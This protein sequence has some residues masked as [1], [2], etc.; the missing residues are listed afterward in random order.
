MRLLVSAKSVSCNAI[1]GRHFRGCRATLAFMLVCL[2]VFSPAHADSG[3]FEILTADSRLEEGKWTVD[4]RI[5]LLLSKEAIAALESG[6]TLR[7]QFLYEVN[8]SRPF[9]PDETI[10][11]RKQ[12]IELRYLSLSQRYA[13]HNLSSGEQSSFATLLSALRSMGQPR[14]FAVIDAA[15]LQPDEDY[16]FAIRA[17]LARDSLPGPLQMLAFWRG[18]FILESEWYRWTLN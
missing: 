1:S 8:R 16:W 12:N 5:D 18:D 6:V 2:A 3:R 17:V 10:K 7:I 9:W 13:V 15:E 14:D 11:D 4:A